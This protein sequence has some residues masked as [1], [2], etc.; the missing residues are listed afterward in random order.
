MKHDLNIC[1]VAEQFVPPVYDG[2]TRVYEMWVDL[3]SRRYNLYAIFFKSEGGDDCAAADAYLAGVCNAHL[4][5]PGV[6]RNRLW[7]TARAAARLV[8]GKLFAPEF[9][10]ELGRSE[11][12]RSVADFV[13]RHDIDILVLSKIHSIHLFG[14]Q[15]LSR[16][17][18]RVF[19]DLHDDFVERDAADRRV[20]GELLQRFPQLKEYRPYAYAALRHR[21]SRLVTRRARVQEA[22]LC[23][24]ADC[25]LSSSHGEWSRYREMMGASVP[26]EFLQWPITLAHGMPDDAVTTAPPA[27]DAGFLGG[28]NP[29]N[30]EAVLFFCN[31]VLPLIRQKYPAFKLLIAGNVTTPLA[32]VAPSWAGVSFEGFVDAVGAFYRQ[33]RVVIVPLL[34]GT[35]VSVKTLEAV[36]HGMPIVATPIGVRGIDITGL[37]QISVASDPCEFAGR[38]L[39]ILERQECRRDAD[40]SPATSPEHGERRFLDAFERL[41]RRYHR[42]PIAALQNRP[43][44]TLLEDRA[45]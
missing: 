32:L 38:V 14:R 8:S 22:A 9:I 24:L 34:S 17:T 10:E 2:S 36:D 29:F 6:P 25:L 35:G 18:A 7:K 15:T 21:L 42:A 3:L 11:I 30:L 43:A 31:R 33:V 45:G 27:F 26:C 41:L 23:R 16:M 40:R 4:I 44:E 1:F 12:R 28:D 39:E 20:L 37:P 19:L 5:L 13:A